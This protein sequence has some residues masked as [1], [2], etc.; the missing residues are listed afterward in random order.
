M[1]PI[2]K[3]HI[4]KACH[5]YPLQEKQEILSLLFSKLFLLLSDNRQ[6]DLNIPDASS[7]AILTFFLSYLG[8]CSALFKL[9]GFGCFDMKLLLFSEACG[10]LTG[11]FRTLSGAAIFLLSTVKDFLS[12]FLS[13]Y[14]LCFRAGPYPEWIWYRLTGMGAQKNVPRKQKAQL[15][16]LTCL[17]VKRKFKETY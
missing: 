10:T 14:D 9:S 7:W 11:V 6:E 15:F 4:N 13:R 16:T 12:C 17:F 8:T 3:T 5:V 1:S 2:L